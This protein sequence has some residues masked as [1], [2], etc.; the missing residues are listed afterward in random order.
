MF[1][2]FIEAELIIQCHV[3]FRRIARDSVTHIY[4]VL[5]ILFPYRLLQNAAYSLLGCTA[6]PCWLSTLFIG[7]C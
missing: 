1:F 6:G 3:I 2:N 7:V 4:I 5:Q